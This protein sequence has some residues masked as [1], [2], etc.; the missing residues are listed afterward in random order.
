MDKGREKQKDY[1]PSLLD[2]LIKPAGV[3]GSDAAVQHLTEGSQLPQEVESA[4]PFL[5]HSLCV[6][7]PVQSIADIH[8]NIFSSASS[9]TSPLAHSG[10]ESVLIF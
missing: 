1:R 8:S 9:T 5:A 7:V 3:S 6:R 4:H 10:C 2:E